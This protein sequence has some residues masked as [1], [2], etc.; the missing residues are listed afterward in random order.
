MT[1]HLPQPPNLSLRRGMIFARAETGQS[2]RQIIKAYRA[3]RPKGHKMLLSEF[4]RFRLYRFDHHPEHFIGTREAAELARYVNSVSTKKAIVADKLMFDAALRGLGFPVPEIQAAF[5]SRTVRNAHVLQDRA[6]VRAF[7]ANEARFP[8]FAKPVAGQ[9][10]N[11]A[12][13]I[14]AYDPAENTFTLTHGQIVKAWQILGPMEA[15][16]K[17]TGYVFQSHVRQHPEIA[18][19]IG[20]S[21]GTIRIVTFL[22]NETVQILGAY[23]KIPFGGMSADNLNRGSM[24]APIALETGKTGVP[25]S[26]LSIDAK[27]SPN[28]PDTG[29]VLQ[30][31]TLPDWDKVL[32]L[33]GDAA[34]LLRGMPLV[35]W[36]IA[37]GEAGPIVIEAN[38]SPS[39]DLLQ[40]GQSKGLMTDTLRAAFGAEHDRLRGAKRK[41]ATLRKS[42]LRR[43]VWNRLIASFGLSG[44]K[45]G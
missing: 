36:D 29:A 41:L 25:L 26:S 28:H 20:T 27:P 18:Q 11:G 7:F 10:S 1:Q 2:R 14:K 35:G 9:N 32:E 22:A 37:M 8:I 33:A 45:D 17:Q 6:Q 39:L 3:F 21:V 13:A 44:R 43:I 23:W 31:M 40:I 15:N 24:I 12:F 38:A 16:H 42:R 30:G 4:L 34:K 5:G 19:T